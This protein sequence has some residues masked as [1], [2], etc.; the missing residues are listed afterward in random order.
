MVAV[1]FWA[2]WYTAFKACNC[3]VWYKS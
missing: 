2:T 1:D 3:W